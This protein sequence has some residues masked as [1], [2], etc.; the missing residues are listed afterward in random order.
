[1]VAVLLCSVVIPLVTG[2]ALLAGDRFSPPVGRRT[3]YLVALAGAVATAVCVGLSV[4]RRPELDHEWVP[5]IGMRLHLAID[6]IS[7]PLLVLTAVLGVLVVLHGHIEPP[8]RVGQGTFFGCLLLVTGGAIATFLARDAVLFFLAFEVVLIPMWWLIKGFGDPAH[9]AGAAAK[10]VLYTV[11]GSTLMLV[12]ILGMVYLAGTSD[13]DQLVGGAGMS[14]SEQTVLAAI[15]LV[16]LG[17]KVPIWPLH[18]WLPA[19]HTAAPTTGS[20]LLAAV[21]LKMGTYGVA[22][23]VVPTLPDG[24]DNVAPYVAVLAAIG[25]I[26]GGLVCLVERSLKRLIAWSSIAHMGFVMLGLMSGTRLGLQAALF[27]N[28][29]HGVVSALLF[30]VVGGLKHRWDGD[31]LTVARASLR[32]TAPRLGFALVIGMAASLGLPGLAGFW[33][34]LLAIT[35]TWSPDSDRPLTLFRVLAAVAALGTVLAAAYALRVLRV[36]WAEGSPAEFAP[37]EPAEES[38]D[39]SA[40]E[41]TTDPRLPIVVPD[42]RGIEWLVVGVLVLGTVGLGVLPTI[43]LRTTEP[44]V[45]QLLGVTGR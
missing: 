43:L 10:F 8:S 13:I 27:A 3:S 38:E 44:D 22:R 26:W 9:R 31:D 30:V 21:L 39:E 41:P 36:V 42:A 18:S 16:G 1:M 33:G 24:V 6:G 14:T 19:A 28:I 37:P 5:A 23:L 17:I 12:G 25:I 35:S 20:V 2:V 4:W 7:A 40:E 11:L 29:A 45:L 15:L 32:D 34:E